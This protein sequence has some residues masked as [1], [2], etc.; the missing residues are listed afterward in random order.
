MSLRPSSATIAAAVIALAAGFL[1]G[2]VPKNSVGSPQIKNSQVK[3]V[4]L[5]NGGVTTADVKDGT[6]TSADLAAG[7]MPQEVFLAATTNS[8]GGCG[9]PGWCY[10]PNGAASPR[11]VAQFE[12]PPANASGWQSTGQISVG[13]PTRINFTATTNMWFF[14][15]S[16]LDVMCSVRDGASNLASSGWV[17]HDGNQAQTIT[18]TGSTVL[19]AGDHLIRYACYGNG[20]DMA[21]PTTG[22]INITGI[23]TS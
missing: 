22:A 1:A 5:Q 19:A 9:G 6:L 8:I 3:S 11:V 10:V 21:A 18:V 15:T 16:N 2:S 7:T 23:P 17:R 4:D 20:V 14:G 13:V 12:T